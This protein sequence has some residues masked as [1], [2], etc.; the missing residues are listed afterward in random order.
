M[1]VILLL[2]ELLE[3]RLINH[4][5]I[6]SKNNA[7]IQDSKPHVKTEYIFRI[8]LTAFHRGLEDFAD[9]V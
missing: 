8:V 5:S 3:L 4:H 6:I 7:V 1:T 2:R 9:Y